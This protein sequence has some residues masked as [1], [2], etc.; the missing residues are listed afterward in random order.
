MELNHNSMLAAAASAGKLVL[1]IHSSAAQR[2]LDTK[3]V[4]G[5]S[6]K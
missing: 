6:S 5:W 2:V 1:L 3:T 4:R